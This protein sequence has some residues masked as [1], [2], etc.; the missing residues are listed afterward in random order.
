MLFIPILGLLLAT[1][2]SAF[3]EG[4]SK[5]SQHALFYK[6]HDLSSLKL[7]E[8]AGTFSYV[9]TAKNNA[10]RPAYDILED[11]GMNSVRLRIWVNP[12]DGVY[13][14][15]YT[16]ELAKRFQKKGYHIY[17]DFHF[18]DGWADPQKQPIPA[19]WPTD[20]KPLSATLRK[21]VKNTLLAF[22]RAHVKLDIVS[23]GNEIRHGM[24]WPTAY[25]DVDVQ[26]YPALVKNFTNLATLY[27]A[28]R[29]GVDDAIK[30]G[31]HKPQV[32]I[33]LDNGWNTTF[34]TR[35]YSAL[36]DNGVKKSAFDVVGVSFYPFYG[37]SA[38]FENLRSSLNTLVKK[39]GKPVQVVETDY[40]AIC[41]GQWNPIP[42]SSEPE[43]QFN[44]KG[45]IEW[46]G[47]VIDIVK[48]VPRGLGQGVFYWEPA[49]LNNTSLGSNCT[50]ALLFEPDF[51]NWPETVGYSRESVNFFK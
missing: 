49:W 34:Q 22:Q 46:M 37:T 3:P 19:A 32:M 43:I 2:T 8:D 35:W 38:T 16:L 10:T 18:A 20:L 5:D 29:S 44:V 15:Q 41:D 28:A 13:G 26:P 12:P 4:G 42:E 45:Q 27:K 33:H 1:I 21:Y 24:L 40:P 48:N 39:Y 25:V 50:D 30:A 14:L 17:L 47:K 31:A 11:G 6:G 51:S 7:L 36:I 9:D 23:L